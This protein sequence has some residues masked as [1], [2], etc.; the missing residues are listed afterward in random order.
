MKG[1]KPIR[2]VGDLMAYL[3][4]CPQDSEVLLMPEDGEGIP[5]GGVLE[6]SSEIPPVVWIL[7]DEFAEAGGEV[8]EN[9]WMQKHVDW[10]GGPS[11]DDEPTERPGDMA[12]IDAGIVVLPSAPKVD[13]VRVRGKLRSA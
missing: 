4:T 3:G 5:V 8:M 13:V 6:F 9:E 7:F 11:E 1:L 2:T 10:S 12:C